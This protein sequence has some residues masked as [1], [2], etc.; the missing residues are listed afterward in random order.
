MN[1]KQLIAK[2]EFLGIEEK[3][4]Y[5][6]PSETELRVFE[7]L[8]GKVAQPRANDLKPVIEPNLKPLPKI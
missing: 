3:W 8:L 2:L 6:K 5:F 1:R 4:Q 7:Q